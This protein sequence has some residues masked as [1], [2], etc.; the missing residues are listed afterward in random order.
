M[1]RPVPALDAHRPDQRFADPGVPVF[2]N[3]PVVEGAIAPRFY[4]Y[5]QIS[6]VTAGRGTHLTAHDRRAEV[7]LRKGSACGLGLGVR[8][9]RHGKPVGYHPIALRIGSGPAAQLFLCGGSSRAVW[10]PGP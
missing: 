2:V 6:L 1:N 3:H 4:R 7:E 5:L 8:A 10:L 9:R